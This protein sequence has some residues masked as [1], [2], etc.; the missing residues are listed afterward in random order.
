MAAPRLDGQQAGLDQ[1]GQ[2][3][4]GVLRR[5]V[6]VKRQL[7]GGSRLSTQQT[8]EHHDASRLSDQRSDFGQVFFDIHS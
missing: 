4:A 7:A 8:P 1:P 5:D 6:R 3:R 2:V